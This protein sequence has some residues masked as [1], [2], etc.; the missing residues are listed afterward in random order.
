MI[1]AP[2]LELTAEPSPSWHAEGPLAARTLRIAG[3]VA[4]RLAAPRTRPSRPPGFEILH[5]PPEHVGLGV[6][7]QLSLAVARVL[8]AM[9]GLDTISIARPRR[10]DRARTSLGDRPARVRPRRPDRRRGPPTSGGIP[11][12]LVRQDFPPDWGVLVVIPG[13]SRA[14]TVP[15]RSRHSPSSLPCPRS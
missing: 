3:R 12:L 4:D 8:V 5:A 7:T 2:G 14:C 13:P 1:D 10:P 6:G 9:A 11:P 15:R